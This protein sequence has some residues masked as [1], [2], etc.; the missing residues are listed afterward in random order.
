[1]T[2]VRDATVD[3]NTMTDISSARHTVPNLENAT[4]FDNTV[5]ENILKDLSTTSH[6]KPTETMKNNIEVLCSLMMHQ[7]M[8]R[9]KE[10]A[11]SVLKRKAL[12]RARN[13]KK[14]VSIGNKEVPK[15]LTA[16]LNTGAGPNLLKE[17]CLLRAWA[18]HAFTVKAK[19]LRAAANTQ[20]K[21]KGVVRLAVQLLE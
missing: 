3:D 5:Q 18:G 2:T 17:N 1:M 6:P 15:M 13:Y 4:V 11:M 12:L 8:A 21:V 9:R 14:K 10:K 20:R 16:I 7:K 19:R